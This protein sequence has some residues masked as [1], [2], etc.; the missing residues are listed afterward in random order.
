MTAEQATEL[1]K[2]VMGIFAVLL[3]IYFDRGCSD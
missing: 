1:L 3:M 2:V